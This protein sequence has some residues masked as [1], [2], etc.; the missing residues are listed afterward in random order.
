MDMMQE[1]MNM[2]AM[3]NQDTK[4]TFAMYTRFTGLEK[5]VIQCLWS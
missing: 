4:R 2:E 3:G 1:K 5:N